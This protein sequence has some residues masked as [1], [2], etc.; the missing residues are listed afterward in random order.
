MY[1]TITSK[2]DIIKIQMYSNGILVDIAD[3][4][5]NSLHGRLFCFS[6]EHI[7]T[8]LDNFFSY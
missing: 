7:K 4:L 3:L 2:T 1:V 8:Q 5:K 6:K